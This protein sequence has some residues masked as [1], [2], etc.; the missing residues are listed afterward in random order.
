MRDAANG[1]TLGL[2]LLEILFVVFIMILIPAPGFII[3]NVSALVIGLLAGTRFRIA[4]LA[5]LLLALVSSV[6]ALGGFGLTPTGVP[7]FAVGLLSLFA[8]YVM[9]GLVIRSLIATYRETSSSEV[10]STRRS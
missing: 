9:V 8:A 6:L 7:Y 5:R 4:P 3:L 2:I 10:A 1:I